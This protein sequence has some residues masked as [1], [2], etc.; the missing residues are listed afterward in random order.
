MNTPLVNHFRTEQPKRAVYV[1]PMK[2]QNT[3][4]VPARRRFKPDWF[5]IITWG[6]MLLVTVIWCM[7][8]ASFFDWLLK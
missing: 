2:H 4:K 6:R 3:F 7:G 8:L 5:N 1:V